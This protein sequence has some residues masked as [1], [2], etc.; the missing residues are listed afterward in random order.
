MRNRGEQGSLQL[1]DK[2]FS[3][4][5]KKGYLY[6]SLPSRLLQHGHRGDGDW[7]LNG[8]SDSRLLESGPSRAGPPGA[9]RAPKN[10]RAS[11]HFCYTMVRLLLLLLLCVVGWLIEWAS[12]RVREGD[13]HQPV[14]AFSCCCGFLC[15]SHLQ[16][17]LQQR[18]RSLW[19][20]KAEPQ[21][22]VHG[23]QGRGL[24]GL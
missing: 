19:P 21:P 24:G 8:D 23:R 6:F 13:V 10:A 22:A 3:G 11:R 5:E 20:C 1:A 2:A 7:Q 17:Q 18:G 16:S 14:F 9:T 15:L 12:G 4:E